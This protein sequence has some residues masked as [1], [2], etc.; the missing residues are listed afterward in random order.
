MSYSI[1]ETFEKL[2]RPVLDTTSKKWISCDGMGQL[3]TLFDEESAPKAVSE[4]DGGISCL[5][6]SPLGNHCVLGLGDYVSLREYPNAK[7]MVDIQKS[8][9]GRRTLPVNHVEFDKS[10]NNL[11]ISSGDADILVHNLTT[12]EEVKINSHGKGV[13]TFSLSADN[14]HMCFV[15]ISGKVFIVKFSEQFAL[16]DQMHAVFGVV[17]QKVLRRKPCKLSWNP[18]VDNMVALPGVKGMCVVY[19]LKDEKWIETNIFELSDAPYSHGDTDL[20]IVSFSSDGKCLVTADVEGKI[21]IWT[22]KRN[23]DKPEATAVGMYKPVSET[24]LVDVVFEQANDGSYDLIVVSETGTTRVTDVIAKEHL[25]VEE[26]VT[27]SEE[28]V[29]TVTETQVDDAVDVDAT[30]TTTTTT[31]TSDSVPIPQ[32]GKKRL[33]KTVTTSLADDDDDDEAIFDD[34]FEQS[35]TTTATKDAAADSQQDDFDVSLSEIKNRV[36]LDDDEKEVTFADDTNVAPA[37]SSAVVADLDERIASLEEAKETAFLTS[38]EPFQPSESVND[39]KGRRYLVYNSV[40]DITLREDSENEQNRV[41]IRFAN[42]L[43]KNKNEAFPENNGYRIASLA[44]EGAIFATDLGY[45]SERDATF[46][47]PVGSKIYY[48]AFEGW[49]DNNED[50]FVDLNDNEKALCVAVGCGWCATATS[51]GFLRIYSSSGVQLH[52]YLLKGP[53]ISIVG[54]GSQL[55]VFYNAGQPVDGTTKVNLDVYSIFYDS[56][57]ANRCVVS[58]MA[59]PISKKGKLMWAGFDKD[60]QTVTMIDSNGLMSILMKPLGWQWVPVLDINKAKKSIDHEYWPVSVSASTSK[61]TFVLLN[62]EAKPKV[63]PRPTTSQKPF[64]V[65]VTESKEGKDKGADFN[66]FSSKVVY[67]QA[68]ISHADNTKLDQDVYGLRSVENLDEDQLEARYNELQKE[69][70]ASVLKLFQIACKMQNITRAMDLCYRIRSDMGIEAG[71][72]IANNFGIPTVAVR[73]EEIKEHRVAEQ[74]AAAAVAQAQEFQPPQPYATEEDN[75]GEDDGFQHDNRTQDAN[76]Y[77]HNDAIDVHNE[78]VAVDENI[79]NQNNFGLFNGRATFKNVTPVT[80]HT[81]APAFDNPFKRNTQSPAKKRTHGDLH[82][83]AKELKSSPSP[84]LNKIARQSSFSESA[85]KE[86][87]A[88][89]SIM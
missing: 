71:I 77:E 78:P 11:L 14:S 64:F 67:A 1:A 61:F 60:F 36:L 23:V 52:V 8:I 35:A 86:K 39:D 19:H 83:V 53:V 51:T 44:N 26:V 59:V 34:S 56:S 32:P 85:R 40:G 45:P 29:A 31:T 9:I 37:P 69:A 74:E 50:F 79:G 63:F 24:I 48:K 49:L 46:L 25:E 65:P 55:A 70:D 15:D 68:F 4:E 88:R 87:M 33:S 28:P 41:E 47:D 30:T 57:K 20:Q 17:P 81:E 16:Y 82:S 12:R 72:T 43:S 80:S 38:Q 66:Q 5:A 75:Y 54:S 58:D 76:D 10:G 21:V 73:L 13:H 62:G 89:R 84:K 7:D 6:I 27:V 3:V 18:S 22:M 42:S 2:G